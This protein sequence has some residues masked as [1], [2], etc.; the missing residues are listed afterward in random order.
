[1]I[2][3][4]AGELLAQ[5]SLRFHGLGVNAPGQGRVRIPI[6]DPTNEWSGPPADV[7]ETD[8]TIELW[9]KGALSDN[10]AG[11]ITCGANINWINGNIFLDRDRYNQG[12]K[13]GVSLGAGMPVW[14]VTGPLGDNRTLCAGVNVL[15]GDWHHLAFQR[16]RSDGW[17]WIHVDGV[18]VAQGDGPD[19]DLSYPDD[20]VPGNFCGGPCLNSDPYLVLGAEKHDAGASYPSFNGL[21][22]ELRISTTLRYASGFV[23][24]SLPF[25]TDQH[26]A[27]L[28]HFNEGSGTDLTDMSGAYGGPSHGTLIIGGNPSGPE[29]V[30]DSPFS[31]PAARVDL[32]MLLSGPYDAVFQLM[33]DGLRGSGLIPLQEP[34][35]GSGFMPVGYG[36]GESTTLNR[37]QITGEEAVVDWVRIELLSPSDTSTVIATRNALVTRSGQVVEPD[38]SGPGVVMGY[39]TLNGFLRVGH[40]NH[41]HA[42]HALPTL[43]N[44]LAPIVDLSEAST[45]TFGEDAQRVF[46]N[47]AALWSGDTNGNGLVSYVGEDNDR[48]PIL[49]A[50]GGST[51][52]GTTFGYISLDVNM[53]GTVKYV[54]EKNDRDP[55]LV[56]IGGNTPTNIRAAQDP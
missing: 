21:L 42:T 56:V 24:A 3:L 20:G 37:L 9:L 14:G 19:G 5:G 36:G 43:M 55:I 35:T 8:F 16:R 47:R 39:G 1:M 44:G 38:G 12:R 46:D 2:L 15:D 41:L 53:D 25:A 45:L 10:S 48:D 34:Y 29:W 11:P 17:L 6:D 54:G 18:L 13:F 49:L 52:T 30:S 27:A 51:P 40:R 33:G 4:L 32:R 7:G 50:I 22:D 23:P 28:Y 26:T 31:T